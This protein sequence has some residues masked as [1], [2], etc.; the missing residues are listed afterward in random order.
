MNFEAPISREWWNA[1]TDTPEQAKA[2][3]NLHEAR[4][5]AAKSCETI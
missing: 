3:Y 2:L 1:I 4:L 5:R